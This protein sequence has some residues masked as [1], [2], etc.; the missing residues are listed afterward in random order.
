M[1]KLLIVSWVVLA[2][3][4]FSSV[5]II[6]GLHEEKD[7]LKQNNDAL[8]EKADYYLLESGK[9]AAS[10]QALKLSKSE[11]EKH[12]SDLTE[13]VKELNVKIKRLQ[14]ASTT[15]TRTDVEVKTVVRDSIVYTNAIP[16]TLQM[17]SWSD[18][19]ISIQGELRKKE[20]SLSIQSTDTLEQIV[21]RVPKKFLFFR[22]GT[23]AIRQEIVS[24]N[25]HTKIVYSEY[26]ELK[27]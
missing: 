18:N 16:D 8:M 19:W 9:S 12:C 11:I 1:K 13:T 27:K 14:S 4:C 3:M 26:I 10:V 15:A 5:K 6:K 24:R 23:K 7:R 21:H 22:W 25:P 2:V 17:I 20:L